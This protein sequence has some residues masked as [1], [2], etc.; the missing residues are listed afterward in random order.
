MGTSKQRGFILIEMLAVM[1]M[2]VILAA[3]FL[4][5]ISQKTA[6]DSRFK[7]A[8][9][10]EVG[11]IFY[12]GDHAGHY[13]TNLIQTVPYLRNANL[14][15]NG[16]NPFE[17]I[18]RGSMDDLT[19]YNASR[20]IVMRSKPWQDEDGNWNRIYGFADGHCET[21]S[22]PNDNFDRWELVHSALWNRK[23]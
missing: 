7:D 9:L 14:T 12:A 2:F 23:R 11:M 17:I 6:S 19:N 3:L 4:W 22:Q 10:Y 8:S 21:Q 5:V 18:F 15:P 13:P 20:I 16:S 1:V